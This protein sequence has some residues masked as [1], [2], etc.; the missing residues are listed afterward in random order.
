T[1]YAKEMWSFYEAGTMSPA[2]VLSGEF[3]EPEDEADVGG[4]LRV[5][6]AAR[7]VEARRQAARAADD[8]PPGKSSEV[9]PPPWME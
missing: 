1:K 6:E 7:L 5:I 3:V 4:V 8:A 2:T 9:P